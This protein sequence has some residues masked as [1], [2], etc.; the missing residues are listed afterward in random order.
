LI[1]I[2]ART[3]QYDAPPKYPVNEVC[4]NIDGAAQGATILERIFL[5]VEPFTFSQNCIDVGGSND[6]HPTP[7]TLFGWFWQV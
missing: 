2:Y 1:G 4:K 5:G 7:D 3:A 6:Y